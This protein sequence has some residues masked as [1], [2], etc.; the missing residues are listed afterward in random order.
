MQPSLTSR[1]GKNLQ[2]LSIIILLLLISNRST[3]PVDRSIYTR[4]RTLSDSHAFDFT[5]WEINALTRKV[6]F[7]LLAPQRFMDGETQSRFVLSYLN[8]IHTS[9]DLTNKIAKAYA[10]PGIQSPAKT[11]QKIQTELA[12]LRE[13]FKHYGPVAEAILGEQVSQVLAK[14][15]F[16]TLGQIFPP[17]SGT[18]TPL[19]YI[20][21]ISP[22]EHIESLYQ[23]PLIAGL[24]A[25]QQVSIEQTVEEEQPELSAYVTSIG[26][27]A[28]YPAMLLENS[29]ID[30]VTNL[31]AHEWTH[32]HLIIFPLGWDYFEN[33][34]ARTIN[35][36]TA[37]L[38]GEWAGHEIMQ[39]FYIPLLD[40][41]KPLPN[42]V[43]KSSTNKEQ[44]APTF[45]FNAEMRET[46]LQVDALLAAGKITEAETYMEEQRWH[47]VRYGYN[48]RRLNQ[49]YFAFHG[50]YAN[51]PGASGS[52]PIG[53]QVRKL[54]AVSP[55]PAEFVKTIAYATTL[56]D[57]ERIEQEIL[58]QP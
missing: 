34:E 54:W 37:S 23:R 57:L 44:A 12:K 10:D 58:S 41:P 5:T 32:H 52:D 43:A 28:A 27:L 33:P 55:S 56:E 21:V 1:L 4:L 50:A 35:E 3:V 38:I 15:G 18:F 19:P 22:R 51:E 39:H 2:L 47:F 49:A 14:G 29:D 53:P 17:V 7:G 13:R 9:R 8:D 25:A 20:L 24:T 45:N 31:V 42:P 6:T 26:G 30:W 40:R 16:G 36:T 48:L 11:T 46:R